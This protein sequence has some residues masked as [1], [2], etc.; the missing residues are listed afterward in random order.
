MDL[1]FGGILLLGFVI[2]LQHALEADHVAAVTS[3]A[4]GETTLKRIVAHGLLW[5]LGH[6]LTLG[7]IAGTAIYLGRTIDAEAAGWLEFTV[8]VM[9]VVLGGQVIWRIVMERIHFHSHR[10]A[11]GTLHLHAH[12]HA[13]EK[14]PHNPSAHRHAHPQRLPWRTLCV[15]LMHGMAGSAALVVLSASAVGDPLVGMAYVLI[16][17]VGSMIGMGF[18][19]MMIAV[20]LGYTAK[21]LTW[22]NRFLQGGI[23]FVTAGLGFVVIY[24][25]QLARFFW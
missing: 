10:H 21:T 6:T 11:D 25:T 15:G 20:P 9:L 4:S 13:G 18:L 7:C 3:I 1:T 19:S 24:N 2:G 14:A 8:G 12:S 16:F 17:G 23:G 22:A 5:G